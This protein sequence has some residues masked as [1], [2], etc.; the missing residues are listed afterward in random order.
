MVK[1]KNSSSLRP[2]GRHFH[3]GYPQILLQTLLYVT[4]SGGSM[5]YN[6]NG[7]GTNGVSLPD[8]FYT[9]L[10]TAQTNG[11]ALPQSDPQTQEDTNGPPSL[12]L[13]S[14]RDSSDNWYPISEAEATSAGWD[15]YLVQS[16][17]MPPIEMDG[18]LF[19]W[20]DVY[21][22]M[23][24]IE[25]P[26]D[27]SL[28]TVNAMNSNT[29]E[30]LGPD[31][32][33]A[34]S[35]STRGFMR[36]PNI[37]GKGTIGTIGVG[38]QTYYFFP[39]FFD[40]PPIPTGWPFPVQP[41]WVALDGGLGGVSERW[42][43]L[44]E[45]V[46]LAND[47]IAAMKN[48]HFK[49]IVVKAN[50]ALT[51][52]DVVS[53]SQIG[54]SNVFNQVNIG[55]LSLHCSYGDTAEADGIRRTYL[56]FYNTATATASYRTLD[57]CMFG[58]PGT[59]GLKYMALLAC[60]AL[61]TNNYNDLYLNQKLPISNDLHLLLT[62]SSVVTAAPN[63]GTYWGSLLFST[64]ETVA[65]AWFDAGATAYTEETNNITITFRVAGW[66]DA[67]TETVHEIN[68]S[69]GTGNPLDIQ[70]LDNQVYSMP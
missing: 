32:A 34:S 10:L 67:F 36:P 18:V 63:L 25:V 37:Q 53:E 9:Y 66:P 51:P 28:D 20:E 52:Y 12:Q 27:N 64:G 42:Y 14:R 4:G 8:G 17:P 38:Y 39:G 65:T 22:P 44:R 55:F 68:N 13:N 26:I 56:R 48:R 43:P 19:S 62:A 58:S 15:Y 7:T 3:I 54:G 16:P 60:N 46:D 21:G 29:Q 45:N 31:F 50:D 61:R 24:L 5:Q 41:Q 6:W 59:N 49:P 35:Q 23:P 30:G 47:F 11:L 40:T 57:Q 69:P 70:Y 2:P 1:A 33:G